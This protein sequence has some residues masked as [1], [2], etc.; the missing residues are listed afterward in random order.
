MVQQCQGS[1]LCY[2]RWT[3]V[4]PDNDQVFLYNKNAKNKHMFV[5]RWV[6]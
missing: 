6:C 4:P 5:L 3:F 2:K 1:G